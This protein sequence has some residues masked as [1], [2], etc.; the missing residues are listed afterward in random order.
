MSA[1]RFV[2]SELFPVLLIL[3]RRWLTLTLQCAVRIRRNTESWSSKLR[4]YL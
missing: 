2:T 1:V 4:R 3:S